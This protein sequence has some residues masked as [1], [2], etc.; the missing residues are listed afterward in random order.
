MPTFATVWL[1]LVSS[2]SLTVSVPRPCACPASVPLKL[3]AAFVA[4]VA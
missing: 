3:P 4:M 2:T 1:L